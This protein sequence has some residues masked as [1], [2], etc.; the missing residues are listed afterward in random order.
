MMIY[1]LA[2]GMTLTM[3]IATAFALHQEATNAQLLEK[4]RKSTPFGAR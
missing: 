4:V 3:L 1:I 2:A